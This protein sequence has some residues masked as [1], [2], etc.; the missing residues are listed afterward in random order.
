MVDKGRRKQGV[1]GVVSCVVAVVV[2]EL[3]ERLLLLQLTDCYRR[4][5][6]T[7]PSFFN[8]FVY[9]ASLLSLSLIECWL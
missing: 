4:Y 2:C 6:D 3:T 1:S 8:T 9:P 7:I 5:T